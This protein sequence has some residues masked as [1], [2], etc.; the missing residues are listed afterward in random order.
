[1]LSEDSVLSHEV[2]CFMD[3]AHVS[4]GWVLFVNLTTHRAVAGIVNSSIGKLRVSK[5]TKW[6]EIH[7]SD[8]ENW[9]SS[10]GSGRR[11]VEKALLTHLPDTFWQQK[12]GF[13]GSL[14]A[15]VLMRMMELGEPAPQKPDVW[16][17]GLNS[18][19]TAVIACLF[20][21]FWLLVINT[22]MVLRIY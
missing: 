7:T 18:V 16:Q 5:A 8:A 19:F 6:F 17:L 22:V 21:G 20:V 14:G 10:A 11:D 1:M 15:V 3:F 13:R 2:F 12:P 4:A 9:V